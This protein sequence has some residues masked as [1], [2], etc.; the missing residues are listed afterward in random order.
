FALLQPRVA[1]ARAAL[2]A[3]PDGQIDLADL[4][5]T[6]VGDGLL[7]AGVAAALRADLTNPLVL[8]GGRGHQRAF[9]NVVRRGLLALHVLAVLHRPH[10]HER[11]PVVR[12]GDR[13]DVDVLVGDNL[14]DV[15]FVLRRAL[16]LPL[17]GLH[18][19]ADHGFIAIADGGDLAIVLAEEPADVAHP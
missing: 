14:P 9:V 3:Q 5:A 18:R 11:V 12:R 1:D 17:D 10:G 13:D 4:P 6:N 19:A 2:V 15:L 7:H 16:L 8:A